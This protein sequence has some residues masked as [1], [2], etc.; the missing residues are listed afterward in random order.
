MTTRR[1]SRQRTAKTRTA[2]R[3]SEA[4]GES[5][6]RYLLCE[7]RDRA[8]ELW[9]R[10]LSDLRSQ[11]TEHCLTSK[12]GRLQFQ[13]G[14]LIQNLYGVIEEKGAEATRCLSD[15]YWFV[16]NSPWAAH[17][18]YNDARRLHFEEMKARGLT[19]W[20]E[21]LPKEKNVKELLPRLESVAS[22][23]EAHE[24]FI[25]WRR[26]NRNRAAWDANDSGA[27]RRAV[28][29]G[30]L[31]DLPAW[32]PGLSSQHWNRPIWKVVVT[33]L[34]NE[35]LDVNDDGSG[36]FIPWRPA[37]WTN[38]LRQAASLARN[39]PT[40]P[41]PLENWVWWLYP[42]FDRNH[43]SA[44]DV[45]NFAP[46]PP[47]TYL[48]FKQYWVRQGLRFTGEFKK[49]GKD[50]TPPL[51]DFVRHADVPRTVSLEYPV[52]HWD[53]WFSDRFCYEKSGSGT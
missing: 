24:S 3:L 8:T 6:G 53:P 41:T 33:L 26:L 23:L 17:L 10:A 38:I 5:V 1:V 52:W 28:I 35:R 46:Q 49:R 16:T 34:V 50:W 47:M 31:E 29:A 21:F 12:G 44:R 43:W 30:I 9:Q 51:A 13:Q 39:T 42:V 37:L 2:I 40:N 11:L 22:W 36:N 4:E 14:R 20:I 45:W 27:R 15:C 19:P 7:I 18:G 25:E 32:W 48:E